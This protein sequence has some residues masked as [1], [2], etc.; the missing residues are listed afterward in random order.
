MSHIRNQTYHEWYHFLFSYTLLFKYLPHNDEAKS[1]HLSVKINLILGFVTNGKPYWHLKT[2]V[3]QNLGKSRNG[4]E[5]SAGR[6]QGH[7]V[8]MAGKQGHTATVTSCQV[9]VV[10]YCRPEEGGGKR[11]NS[12]LLE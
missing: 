8:Q 1:S 4:G 10:L 9:T 5:D 11:Q 7:R 3:V 12:P 2:D 6:N